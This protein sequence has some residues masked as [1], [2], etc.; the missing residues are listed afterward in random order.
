[1]YDNQHDNGDKDE[2]AGDD[3]DVNEAEQD[4]VEPTCPTGRPLQAVAP[5]CH[6]T[7]PSSLSLTNH[8]SNKS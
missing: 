8:N 7:P 5:C 4:H 1:M 2:H 6:R 3:H